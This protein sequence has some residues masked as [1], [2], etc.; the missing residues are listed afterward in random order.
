MLESILW[1]SVI[2]KV[3]DSEMRF[4]T[5]K[6]GSG[7]TIFNFVIIKTYTYIVNG[8]NYKSDQDLVSD[9]L[10][11]ED[12]KFI[13][14]FYDKYGEY[15]KVYSEYI[16]TKESLINSLI[17]VYFDPNNPKKACLEKGFDKMILSPIFMGL[18]FGT[19]VTIVAYAL[20]SSITEIDI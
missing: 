11:S 2:G 19:G 3:I 9:S 18:L 13:S 15:P 16:K 5:F 10:Y 6:G 1:K 17:T 4:K 14:E 12:Y 7:H 8:N 20:L